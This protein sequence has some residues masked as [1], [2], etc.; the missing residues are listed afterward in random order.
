M[1]LAAHEPLWSATEPSCGWVLPPLA[2]MLAM[3][4]MARTPG[5]PATVKS[6]ATSIRPPRPWGNPLAPATGA[7]IRP[8]PQM[9]QRVLIVGAVGQGDVTGTDGLHADPH[10]KLDAVPLEDPCRVGVALVHEHLQQHGPVVDEMDLGP[11]RERRE[12]VHHRGPD[13]LGQRAGDLDPGRTAAD[14]DEVEGALVDEARVAVGLL[15]GLDDPRLEAVRV[16]ERIEREGVLRPGRPEEVRLG[17]GGQ[18]DVVAGVGLAV[19]VVTRPGHRIDGR[20]PRRAWSRTRRTRP[21]S[22]ASG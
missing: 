16:V 12:L 2:G 17:A 4:P 7:A 8:P 6:G 20:R 22:C 1:V 9:T 5:N 13:H 10:A 3:S 19:R 15:E 21:R 14:D 11:R 18:D